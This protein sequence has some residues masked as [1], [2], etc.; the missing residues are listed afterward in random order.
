MS[1]PAS[2]EVVREWM[3]RQVLVALNGKECPRGWVVVVYA[4]R[5]GYPV[6]F[7]GSGSLPA[8]HMRRAL[9]R[10]VR[11]MDKTGRAAKK[12]EEPDAG[13]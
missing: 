13:A 2:P 3:D 4:V 10:V 8:V 12:L 1:P 7:V 6:A 5:V 11:H 9:R